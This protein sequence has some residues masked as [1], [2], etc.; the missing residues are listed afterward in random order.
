MFIIWE[1]F[2]SAFANSLLKI[3]IKLCWYVFIFLQF[4]LKLIAYCFD[5]W[6]TKSP[7]F[8]SVNSSLYFANILPNFGFNNFLCIYSL[9]DLTI[10]VWGQMDKLMGCFSHDTF[11]RVTHR[12]FNKMVDIWTISNISQPLW[13]DYNVYM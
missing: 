10:Q 1:L 6:F 9:V 11:L 3:T 7:I 13:N 5:S 8:W 4:S 12:V 2:R